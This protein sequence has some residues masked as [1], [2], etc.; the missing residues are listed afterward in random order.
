LLKL[1][2]YLHAQ[3]ATLGWDR[4]YSGSNINWNKITVG[5]HSQGAGTAQIISM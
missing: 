2:I 5:G 1:L 3:N 4:Y